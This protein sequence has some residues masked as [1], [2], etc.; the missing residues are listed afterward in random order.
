MNDF[1]R[2]VSESF[3][4]VSDEGMP[5]AFTLTNDDHTGVVSSP[6]SE[7]KL[8]EPGYEGVDQIIVLAPRVKFARDPEEYARQI[9]QILT[10]P[11]AGKWVVV[12][13]NPDL[14]HYA[15]TCI[16]SD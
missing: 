1:E 7:M 12:A 2:E 9:L 14:A 10:G 3:S 11:W 4:E 15:F 13:T 6:T 5:V 16:P 8:R